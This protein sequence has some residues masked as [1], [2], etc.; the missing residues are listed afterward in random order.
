MYMIKENIL[1]AAKGGEGRGAWAYLHIE[2]FYYVGKRSCVCSE[3]IDF[4]NYKKEWNVGKGGGEEILAILSLVILFFFKEQITK[5]G[6]AGQTAWPFESGLA[7]TIITYF[8]E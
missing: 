2:I 7:D 3:I 8:H 6:H 4:L 1:E 5:G